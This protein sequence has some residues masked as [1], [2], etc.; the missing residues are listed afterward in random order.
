MR[1]EC[2]A[3][4][5]YL[6]APRTEERWVGLADALAQ[7]KGLIS[8]SLTLRMMLSPFNFLRIMKLVDSAY[9]DT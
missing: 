4:G 6:A 9:Y 2:T 7:C 5:A 3:E 8:N 1:D